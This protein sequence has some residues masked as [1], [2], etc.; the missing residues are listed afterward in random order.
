MF[1]RPVYSHRTVI[2]TEYV[3]EMRN[4]SAKVLTIRLMLNRNSM[5]VLIDF[6]FLLKKKKKISL[7]NI[8]GEAKA[9]SFLE[10][11]LET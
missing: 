8:V 9:H 3:T 6:I 10:F 7:S 2:H 5:N 1:C 4:N 11:Q